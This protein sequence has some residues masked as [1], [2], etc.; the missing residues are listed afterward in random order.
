MKTIFI[1]LLSSLS[2]A[3]EVDV[4]I[5]IQADEN[6]TFVAKQGLFS[7]SAWS[8]NF[9]SLSGEASEDIYFERENSEL[10]LTLNS[11]DVLAEYDK[12]NIKIPDNTQVNVTTN[13]ADFLFNGL[14]ARLDG[15]TESG[16]IEITN[17]NSDLSV[18]S[19]DGHVKVEDSSGDFRINTVN[20]DIT[21]INSRGVA[22]IQSV[23]GNQNINA[24]L[25]SVSS[26]NVSGQSLF[27]LRTTEKLNLSNVNGDSSV[28][29]AVSAAANIQMRSV[30]GSLSLL[31]PETTSAKFSIQSHKGGRIHNAIESP[32]NVLD[33]N[34]SAQIF[35]L[36]DASS[37]I[38]M[39]T[40]DGDIKV[41][42]Q[43]VGTNDYAEEYSDFDWSSVDTG[44]LDFAF[45]NPNY[46]VLDYK[47]VYIKPVEVHFSP[48]WE[49]KFSRGSFRSYRERIVNS[50]SELL[51]K[52]ISDRFSRGTHFEISDQRGEDVLVIIPKII[53][54]Y[55]DNPDSVQ[56]IESFITTSAGNAKIDLVLYSPKDESMLGLFMDKR[57]TAV[58]NIISASNLRAINTRAFSRLFD[59]WAKD[60]VSLL[61]RE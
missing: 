12:L 18:T 60:I 26:S 17:F 42:T 2:S 37:S 15:S 38:A 14:N 59:D 39:N 34:D 7:V 29:T 46:N 5:P 27:K 4:K 49:E 54:L 6:I 57:S 50:Y 33:S 8:E 35:T 56:I 31:V 1:C 47:K 58:P 13:N 24:D 48:R 61:S 53:D 25:R 45:I 22:D 52:A 41:A 9:L 11:D 51:E 55:I 23:S 32:I 30:K 10:V 28:E 3:K 20:G 36:A 40:M 19:I 43:V 21:I 16:D 44:I